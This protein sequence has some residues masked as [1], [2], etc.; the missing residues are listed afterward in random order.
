MTQSV[1]QDDILIPIP[2]RPKPKPKRDG[3]RKKALPAWAKAVENVGQ[4]ESP[5]W[6]AILDEARL[7]LARCLHSARGEDDSE[8]LARITGAACRAASN[9][10]AL[11]KL[12]SSERGEL[13]DDDLKGLLKNAMK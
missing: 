12:V 13:S 11:E 4:V 3:P 5:G 8:T 6:P 10:V 9:L 2:P 7:H 1:N